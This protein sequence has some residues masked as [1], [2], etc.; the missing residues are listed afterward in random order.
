M[1]LCAAAL[2]SPHPIRPLG[3]RPVSGATIGF[4]FFLSGLAALIYQVC[5]QRVLFV[6]FGVD[7]ESTTII[8][9]TFMFG[10]GL[11]ALAGGWL[12]DL[13]PRAIPTMFC[14]AELSIAAIGF[15]SVDVIDLVGR[16]ASGW[17]P[18]TVA[19][20]CFLLLLP[21]TLLMGCTLP[22]LIAYCSQR[23]GGI[24]IATGSLYS[25]NT[26]GA[27]L[28]AFL[29]GFVL[30]YW[31]DLREASRVAAAANALAGVAVLAAIGRQR[32]GA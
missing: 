32:A 1:A 16:G 26:F 14:V 30:L 2:T 24:G 13:K 7:I 5:W 10:L 17:P 15:I 20:S 11:G 27:A 3:S 22:M 21:P 29:T 28:G 23:A 4:A 18:A 9:S 6:A 19:V 25:I 12:A 8:V 31:L